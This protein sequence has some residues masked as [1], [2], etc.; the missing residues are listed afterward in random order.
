MRRVLSTIGVVSV[1]LGLSTSGAFAQINQPFK[2][3]T[4]RGN[5]MTTYQACTA[6]NTTS[7][8]AQGACT[9]P[10]R[11]TATCGF[12]G[13]QGKV[14]MK[15]VTVGKVSFRAKLTG[16]DAGCE[17][18]NLTVVATLRRSGQ[19]CA[20]GFCTLVDLVDTP[21]G[22]CV[23]SKGSCSANGQIILPGGTTFG[24]TEIKDVAVLHSGVRAF[25]LGI[26]QNH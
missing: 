25:D 10:V 18:A 26:V 2:G 21:I 13:G 9:P 7:D 8:D 1:V 12:G 4:F 24:Q 16:L 5:L 23:V 3:K 17:G 20:G 15:H 14:Q 11:V 6:P 19:F 22:A